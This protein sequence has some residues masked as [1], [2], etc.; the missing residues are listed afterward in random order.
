MGTFNLQTGDAGTTSPNG[1]LVPLLSDVYLTSS[2]EVCPRCSGSAVGQ[3]G[4]CDSGANQGST[5]T[6]TGVVTVANA[7]GNKLYTLSPDCAP[8]G[9]PAGTIP[10]T[11]P[12]TTGTS[13]LAGSPPCPGQTSISKPGC[14]TCGTVCTGA[15]C[16]TTNAAGQ[17]VDIKGGISQNC[18]ANDTTTPCFTDPI[19]RTG[20][21]APPTPPFPD[22]TYPK[23]ANMTLV[24]TFCEATSGSTLI[25][26]TTGLPGPGALVMP[27]TAVVTASPTTGGTVLKGALASTPGRF[28]FNAMLGLP[29]ANAACNTNFAGTHAC[30]YQELQSAAASGDLKGLKDVT[31]MTVT[32]FWAIDSSATPLQ[33][34]QDDVQGGSGLNWEYA[35]A[36]TASRGEK[37]ALDNAAG[38]LG[39]LTM[40]LQCNFSGNAWVACCQ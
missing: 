24:A 16:V 4:T 40:N 29:G 23:T 2:T 27:A 31:A 25:D 33:Q 26:I 39:S 1:N 7:A 22:P 10:I 21:T 12:L 28:N 15:A 6:T 38:T 36:H 3:V 35:T 34:C 19:V 37:V 18:C 14:G 11:L 20:S 8:A 9:T 13:T 30:T 32:S 5:C 17:C